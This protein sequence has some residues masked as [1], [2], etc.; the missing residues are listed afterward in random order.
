MK[1]LVCVNFIIAGISMWRYSNSIL[2]RKAY[3]TF[4]IQPSW[5]DFME[6]N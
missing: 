5:L 6:Q 1:T 4:K 3:A 2:V